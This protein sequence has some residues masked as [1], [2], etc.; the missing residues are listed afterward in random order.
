MNHSSLFK[1]MSGRDVFCMGEYRVEMGNAIVGD[2]LT[3]HTLGDTVD[4]I[5][6]L[7]FSA[8]KNIEAIKERLFGTKYPTKVVAMDAQ[9]S[10]TT[11]IVEDLNDIRSVLTGINNNLVEILAR[12]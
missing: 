9:S 10:S 5:N 4:I 1:Q 11:S 12:L 7:V 6:D 8:D 2:G 3:N